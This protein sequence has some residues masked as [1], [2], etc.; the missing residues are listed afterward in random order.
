[1][2]VQLDL[3]VRCKR[4]KKREEHLIFINF[5]VKEVHTKKHPRKKNFDV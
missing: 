2:Y 1:M 3:E 5:G 4:P